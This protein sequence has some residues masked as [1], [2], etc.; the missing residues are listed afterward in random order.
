M[1]DGFKAACVH[2]DRSHGAR[3][4]IVEA[5]KNEEVQVGALRCRPHVQLAAA[6]VVMGWLWGG[7]RQC[8]VATDVLGRGMDIP[9]LPFVVRI[10]TSQQLVLLAPLNS[11]CGA[12]GEL[13]HARDSGG[14]HP[15]S[16]PHG[17]SRMCGNGDLAGGQ[18]PR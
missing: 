4:K 9:N 11:F 16:G 8:C 17:S 7:L 5:F 15:P 18:T 14:V 13:R 6:L 2:G 12:A 10:G 3:H 1:K